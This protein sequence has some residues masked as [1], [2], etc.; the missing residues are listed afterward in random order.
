MVGKESPK[1]PRTACRP[2]LASLLSLVSLLSPTRPPL[3]AQSAKPALSFRER[4][5]VRVRT[6][7]NLPARRSAQR[8][9]ERGLGYGG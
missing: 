7:A 6:L 4:A 8:G 3:C 1:T 2:P 9:G 5:G